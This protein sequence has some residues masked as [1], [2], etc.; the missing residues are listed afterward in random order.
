MSSSRA[1]APASRL[2]R[3]T[4]ENRYG[5]VVLLILVTYMVSAANTG[6][7][8][9]IAVVCVQLA[10]VW[11]VFTVTGS[12]R[13]RRLAGIALM[14]IALATVIG[15]I[16]GKAGGPEADVDG[17]FYGLNTL[18]YLIAPVMILLHLVRRRTVDLETFLGAIATYLLIGMM[19]A[20]AYR[21]LGQVSSQPFFGTGGDGN[22]SDD[23]F[24]SF[25]TLT[26][27]GYGNL[28][29]A[30]NPGQ[31]LAVLEAVLGQLFLVTALAKIVTAW[32]PP[33][34]RPGTVTGAEDP[35][36]VPNADVADVPEVPEVP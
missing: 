31:S 13:A 11:I 6:S 16:V 18:L 36:A 5:L 19:F 7:W 14:V 3:F 35:G 2:H 27:T 15:A 1:S 32:T 26:T 25:I 34:R 24:F 21:T 28:V 10:T 8:G 20:F 23:L 4:P 17:F 12:R 30:A 9:S 29:P 33:M 22:M